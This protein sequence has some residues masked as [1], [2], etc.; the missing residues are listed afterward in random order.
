MSDHLSIN[1][2]HRQTESTSIILFIHSNTHQSPTVGFH[3]MTDPFFHS[4]PIPFQWRNRS[5]P[6][7]HLYG[8]IHILS[9]SCIWRGV[10]A[11]SPYLK[12]FGFHRIS[13]VNQASQLILPGRVKPSISSL[14]K[15]GRKNQSLDR[16]S[17]SSAPKVARPVYRS[18]NIACLKLPT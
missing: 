6:T 12:S 4:V 10:D 13:Y 11:A 9:S 7:G 2:I 8:S 5:T 3:V 17:S 16:N 1:C 18:R 14:S 15:F